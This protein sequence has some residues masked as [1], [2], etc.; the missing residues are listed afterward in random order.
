MY[1]VPPVIN[2]TTPVEVILESTAVVSCSAQGQPRPVISWT[3]PDG[4][5]ADSGDN[6]IVDALT[7]ELTIENPEGHNTGTYTCHAVNRLGTAT[8]TVEIII[9][10]IYSHGR[11]LTSRLITLLDSIELAFPQ[12][13]SDSMC[14]SSYKRCTVESV[15]FGI[16]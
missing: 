13:Y 10:G 7:G 16:I 8:D 11:L 3:I 2:V 6:T 15:H 1:T 9:Q 4:R 14:L 12:Y 5:D